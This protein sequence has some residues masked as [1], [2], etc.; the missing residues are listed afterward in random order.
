MWGCDAGRKHQL[1]LH[2]ANSLG[3]PVL[4][5]SKYG[6][7]RRLMVELLAHLEHDAIARDLRCWP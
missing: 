1:R 3:M 6:H 4:G 5:D 7:Q 2:C